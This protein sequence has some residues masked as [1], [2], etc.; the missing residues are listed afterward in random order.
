MMVILLSNGESS[1]KSNEKEQKH[2]YDSSLASSIER[3]VYGLE[4]KKQTFNSRRHDIFLSCKAT[5][6]QTAG[7]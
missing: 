1:S 5:T 2:H 7:A 3:L 6:V 4:T